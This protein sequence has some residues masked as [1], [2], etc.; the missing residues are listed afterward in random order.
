MSTPENVTAHQSSLI[1][2]DLLI[3]SLLN[4]QD[5]SSSIIGQGVRIQNKSVDTSIKAQATAS[6]SII[7]QGVRLRN[8]L[9]TV[10]DDDS[11]KD[12]S[13]GDDC[14]GD[15]VEE[16]YICGESYDVEN[17]QS[18]D[19]AMKGKFF[20]LSYSRT[21]SCASCEKNWNMCK[22]NTDMELAAKAFNINVHLFDVSLLRNCKYFIFFNFILHSL[23]L[24][25]KSL[26]V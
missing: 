8:E 21:K 26:S 10:E 13:E 11:M 1:E 2:I 5:A 12:E 24:E 15:D 7:G 4:T 23:L 25:Q 16:N 18:D 14:L 9:V 6:S 19:T 3:D 20:P 22:S 17:S